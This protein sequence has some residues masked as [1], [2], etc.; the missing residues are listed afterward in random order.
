MTPTVRLSLNYCTF[1]D[2]A[3]NIV[4][5]QLGLQFFPDKSLALHEMTRVLSFGSEAPP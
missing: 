2:G 1:E 5:C 4:L 3:F